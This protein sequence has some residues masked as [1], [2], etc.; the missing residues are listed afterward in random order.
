MDKEEVKKARQMQ[1]RLAALAARLAFPSGYFEPIKVKR[2]FSLDDLIG[3][4]IQEHRQIK[5]PRNHALERIVPNPEYFEVLVFSDYTFM[6]SCSIGDGG[7][8]HTHFYYFD[9]K[10]IRK[11]SDLFDGY[12]I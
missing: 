9:G 4:T 11:S 6:L 5:N 2:E 8:T 7:G 1:K 12:K 3:K 10:N